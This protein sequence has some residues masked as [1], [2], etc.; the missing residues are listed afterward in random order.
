MTNQA[1]PE[2]LDEIK[3]RSQYP[4]LAKPKS[5]GAY[6]YAVQRRLS[7]YVSRWCVLWN[8]SPNQATFIDFLFAVGAS[9]AIYAQDYILGALLIQVFG[10]WSCVDGEVARLSAQAS[11]KGDFYDTMVDRVTEFILLAALFVSLP[12]EQL[13]SSLT[14]NFLLY[15][16]GI[17]LLTVSS[18]KYRSSFQSNYPKKDVERYFCWI[19]AGSDNRLLYFSIVIVMYQLTSSPQLLNWFLGLMSLAM[20]L[21]Y[22][23]RMWKIGQL[24][25]KSE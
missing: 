24:S 5:D 3:L 11:Q 16:G 1:N 10:I 4:K 21:N 19:S 8:I 20:I 22:G 2:W 25:Q 6:C 13:T 23:F 17:F 12:E 7:L 9:I 14:L 18:E 15:Q